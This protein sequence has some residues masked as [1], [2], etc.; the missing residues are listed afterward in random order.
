M[1]KGVKPEIKEWMRSFSTQ[2]I[3]SFSSRIFP[4]APSKAREEPRSRWQDILHEFEMW[5]ILKKKIS[6]KK[7]QFEG[8]ISILS[9][10][11]IVI[12]SVVHAEVVSGAAR[13]W[14]W[15]KW[16]DKDPSDSF[17]MNY[18]LRTRVVSE[19]EPDWFRLNKLIRFSLR[20]IL[21]VHL[22][23]KLLSAY[24]IS[25]LHLM[26][27]LVSRCGVKL[28]GGV[29]LWRDFFGLKINVRYTLNEKG[30]AFVVTQQLL[31]TELNSS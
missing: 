12:N 29:S 21:Y 24:H 27:F 20:L 19:P 13:V 15:F 10:F 16:G 8:F 9:P 28:G 1:S 2:I 3:P 30:V 22:D 4:V 31:P 5:L 6:L 18:F 11:V 23:A 25:L 14:S 26:L 7:W 17:L